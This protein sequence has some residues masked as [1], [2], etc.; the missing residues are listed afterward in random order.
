[1]AEKV[2]GKDLKQLRQPDE[3][4]VVAG[5]AL[6]WILAHRQKLGIALGA[7]VAASLLAWGGTIWKS[8][9]ES[10]AG[11]ELA[12]ALRTAARPVTGEGFPQA[13]EEPFATRAD[14]TKAATEAFE[15]VRKDHGGSTAAQT[16]TLQLGLLKQQTGD[17]AGAIA[18]LQEFLTSAASGHP[19]RAP[20]LEALGYAQEASGKMA[21]AKESFSKLREAGAP[22]RA[23]YQVARLALLEN[24]PEARD[25]LA[26]VAKDY[27]KDAVA[28]EANLRLEIASLP[29]SKAAPAE[30]PP[31]QKAAQKGK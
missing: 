24:K 26:A 5:K 6:E 4:Q 23:A 14:R 25:M 1:V 22:D 3:F 9:K 15:K 12:Q 29:G 7:V 16:A 19:M 20:A 2:T 13:G 17:A 28:L 10:Q 27:P 8:R 21:E 18:L 31:T 30:A 11:E